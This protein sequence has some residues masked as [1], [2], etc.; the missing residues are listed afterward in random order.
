MRK[1]IYDVAVSLDGYIAG[2]HADITG[3][4]GEG[5]HAQ[6]YFARLQT[7]RSSWGATPMSSAMNTV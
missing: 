1:I 6:D 4:I 5:Q 7:A 2:P 3:F